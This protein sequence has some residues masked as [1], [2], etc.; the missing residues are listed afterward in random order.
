VSGYETKIDFEAIEYDRPDGTSSYTMFLLFN[1]ID[2]V[3]PI[4]APGFVL[5]LHEFVY[6]KNLY[7][8]VARGSAKTVLSLHVH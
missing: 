3:F 8:A 5:L 6:T 4:P 2:A 7:L 1:L